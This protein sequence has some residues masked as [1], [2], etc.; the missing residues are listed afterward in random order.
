MKALIFDMDGT[1]IDSAYAHALAWHRALVEF[2]IDAPVWETHRRIGMSG[3][4]L[5]KGIA[6]QR[7][8][9][10][11]DALIDKLEGRHATL[12]REIAPTI[13]LLPG[14]RD[15]IAHL[16]ETKILYGI[17]TTGKRQDIESSMRSLGL[18]GAAPVV[19]GGAVERVKPEPDLFSECQ[20]RLGVEP[21]QCL[22]VGDAVWDIHAAR[23]AGILAVGLLCGGTGEQELYNAGA[24]RVYADPAALHRAL[25]ELGFER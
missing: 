20:R 8:R 17:A 12:F 19:D 3:R 21:A 1:L 23:R 5:V 14:A 22:V 6:R 16:Q 9:I 15:L 13:S 24:M 11:S 18:N 4:Q 25:D 2:G 10:V 7:E